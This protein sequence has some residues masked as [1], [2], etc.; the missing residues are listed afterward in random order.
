MGTLYTEVELPV[1]WK[2]PSLQGACFCTLAQGWV[3]AHCDSYNYEA[4]LLCG[5]KRRKRLN[6]TYIPLQLTPH[7]T[8]GMGG[9]LS[10]LGVLLHRGYGTVAKGIR[11]RGFYIK[12]IHVFLFPVIRVIEQYFIGRHVHEGP[13]SWCQPKPSCRYAACIEEGRER[14]DHQGQ[15]GYVAVTLSDTSDPKYACRC[16]R[17]TAS[18]AT[19]AK[20][21]NIYIYLNILTAFDSDESPVWCR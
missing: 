2:W 20:Y 4:R 5:T 13:I 3:S 14:E 17:K 7:R 1:G 6:Y 15:R 11:G 16:Q 18:L 8:L 12:M 9:Q 19:F 10:A 21:V